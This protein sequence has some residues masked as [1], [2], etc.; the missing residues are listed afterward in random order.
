MEAIIGKWTGKFVTVAL[1]LGGGFPA[2][3]STSL[4]GKLERVG[5]HGVLLELPKETTF[6]PISSI[7]HISLTEQR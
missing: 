3:K 2:N 7:L 4:E 6:I 5:E 1:R